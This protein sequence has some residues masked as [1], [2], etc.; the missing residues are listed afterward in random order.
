MPYGTVFDSPYQTIDGEPMLLE[1]YP[2]FESGSNAEG[3]SLKMV[4][5]YQ[6]Y[7]SD[8]VPLCLYQPKR[9][10]VYRLDLNEGAVRAWFSV[11]NVSIERE[12]GPITRGDKTLVHVKVSIQMTLVQTGASG[13][14]EPDPLPWELPPFGLKIGTELIEQSVWKYTSTANPLN[15]V[16][17]QP[18]VN[19][20]GVPLQATTTR[21][22]VRM[23]FSF[24]LQNILPAWVYLWTG[25]VNLNEV[26]ICGIIFEP[27]QVKLES[28]GFEAC[29]DVEE[30]PDPNN[31]A[32]TITTPV[33][34][35]RCD[36][37]LLIDPQKFERQYLNVGTHIIQD[38]GLHRLWSATSNGTSIYGTAA[39]LAAYD[40]AEEVSEMMFLNADGDG[41]SPIQGGQQ[42]PTYRIGYIEE[43]TNFAEIGLPTEPPFIWNIE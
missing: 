17:D 21:P 40:N 23:T 41:I 1:G 9:G 33:N 13:G 19:T 20:A 29:K 36:V 2:L 31:P 14:S 18:F 43:L 8:F 12:G 10:Q 28:L 25:K 5:H 37:S 30:S 11:E 38:G 26:K 24:N 39:D 34:Y 4:K 42:T 15:P 7:A 22:L 32:R 35:Y 27:G 3:Y 6:I 16:T